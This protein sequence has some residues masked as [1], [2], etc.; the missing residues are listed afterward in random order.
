MVTGQRYYGQKYQ[1]FSTFDE[2][3]LLLV[4]NILHLLTSLKLHQDEYWAAECEW[5]CGQISCGHMLEQ[6]TQPTPSHIVSAF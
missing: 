5:M 4:T 6:Y 1:L 2:Y 3:L